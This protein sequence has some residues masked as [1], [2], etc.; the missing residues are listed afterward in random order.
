M[1]VFLGLS[2]I[3]NLTAGSAF[4]TRTTRRDAN[5]LPAGSLLI[6]VCQQRNALRSRL[7]LGRG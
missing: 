5:A 7:P 4:R 1:D 6:T 2:D 3:G